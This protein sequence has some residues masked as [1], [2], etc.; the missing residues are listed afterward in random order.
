MMDSVRTGMR[1]STSAGAKALRGGGGTS[2][3][4]TR[5]GGPSSSSAAATAAWEAVTRMPSSSEDPRTRMPSLA[6]A[7]KLMD[8]TTR[9]CWSFVERRIASFTRFLNSR[10]APN[11]PPPQQQR[12]CCCLP[13]APACMGGQCVC[14]CCC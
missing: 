11:P 9:A 7:A 4:R 3:V 12:C 5:G 8:A 2:S 6:A 1:S 13:L 10:L 14:C